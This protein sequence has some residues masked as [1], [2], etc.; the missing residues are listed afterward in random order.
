MTLPSTAT[1][2]CADAENTAIKPVVMKTITWSVFIL[3]V[4]KSSI[5]LVPPREQSDASTGHSIP[6]RSL[7][8]RL[9]PATPDETSEPSVYQSRAV[10]ASEVAQNRRS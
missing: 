6:L 8:S 1:E 10:Y 5:H 4:R 9:L 7:S 3:F 2:S